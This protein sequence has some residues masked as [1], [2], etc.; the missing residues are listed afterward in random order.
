MKVYLEKL[1]SYNIWANSR[2]FE[3]MKD[4]SEEQWVQN[5]SG[6]FKSIGHTLQHILMAQVAWDCR[7]NN[8][9]YPD[10]MANRDSVRTKAE[11]IAALKAS[12]ESFLQLIASK[13]ESE[14]E[15]IIT[16]SDLKGNPFDNSLSEI[17]VHVMNHS[18][19]H[20]GQI[21][22]ILR[23]FGCTNIMATDF[24]LFCR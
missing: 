6:S 19:F 10:W 15:K 16:Y 12:S 7:I 9:S 11:V 3:M 23:D 14:L 20:R 2:L 13:S 8:V 18:T 21:V 22:H 24:I 4:L 1:A 17:I 5:T